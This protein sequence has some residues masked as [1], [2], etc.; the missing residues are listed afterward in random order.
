LRR[1]TST[2]T[3][4]GENMNLKPNALREKRRAARMTPNWARWF[5]WPLLQTHRVRAV[6]TGLYWEQPFT[7]SLY[8]KASPDRRA[9]VFVSKPTGIWW[10]RH[11]HAKAPQPL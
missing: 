8:T 9:D 6:I 2:F 3:E 4:T 10:Q 1:Y 7:Y 11:E 5:R